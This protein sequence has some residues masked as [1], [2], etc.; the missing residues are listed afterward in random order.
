[1][2][3]TLCSKLVL[4]GAILGIACDTDDRA[5]DEVGADAGSAELS[6]M[7]EPDGSLLDGGDAPGDAGAPDGGLAETADAEV[8]GNGPPGSL[9]QLALDECDELNS[10]FAGDEYCIKPPPPDKGFQVHIGPEDYDNP[11]PKYLVQPGEETN[12]YFDAVSGNDEDVFYYFRQFRARPGTHHVILTAQA[13]EGA[14]GADARGR[15]LGG[16]QNLAKDVPHLNRVPPENEGVGMELEANTPLTV[17]L[18]YINTT[19]EPILHEVWINFW[20]KDADEVTQPAEELYAMGGL[21]M[22]IEPGE[23]TTLGPYSC[24]VEKDGRILTMYGHYHANSVR[25]S[26]W[27]VRDGVREMVYEAFDWHDPPIL[28]FNS[29]T[30][31]R[32]SDPDKLKFGGWTGTLDVQA[33]DSIEWECEVHNQTDGVLRFTNELYDGEMCILIGDAVGPS[34]RC[35]LP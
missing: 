35:A 25:F 2:V 11:D 19:D 4:A 14:A 12:V 33:G 34:I 8:E 3:R 10:G 20:Y 30:E 18:H 26:A 21:R 6:V 13:E 29:I 16:T 27:R 9:G 17:N 5:A 23:H 28:E 24:P 32:P 1:M 31:N 7:H 22:A 15:R